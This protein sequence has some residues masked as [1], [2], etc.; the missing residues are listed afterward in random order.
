MLMPLPRTHRWGT[1]SLE[2]GIFYHLSRK[3][4]RHNFSPYF[5]PTYLSTVPSVIGTFGSSAD[6]LSSTLAPA[7]KSWLLSPLLSFA[8]QLLVVGLV[9]LSLG[10]K[11]FVAAIFAQTV[12]FVHWNKVVTS[13]YFLWYLWLL[14][15]LLPTLRFANPGRSALL[16]AGVWAG[17]Q[18]MWLSQA[19]LLE[20]KAQDTFLRV[21]LA[22]LLMV[23]AQVWVLTRLV[24]AWGR[25]RL[26][27]VE[28][29]KQ[30]LSASK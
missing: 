12:L 27:H 23:V 5:L 22:G 7:L 25:A 19:H 1:P 29:T 14:P 17:S 8:P 9:G 16:L 2:H 13:Q 10:R 28:E 18:A 15:L 30:Y 21:W 26:A 20:N 3:D 4:H 11:D 24:A 6:Q